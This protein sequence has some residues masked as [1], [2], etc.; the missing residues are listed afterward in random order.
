VQV[1]ETSGATVAAV[2]SRVAITL[3]YNDHEPAHFDAP[4]AGDEMRDRISDTTV[5][6]G[7]LPAAKRRVV[8]TWAARHREA[9]ALAW[10][11]CRDGGHPGRIGE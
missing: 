5:A 3:C 10:V 9:L 8:L 6:E 1:N 7:S 4:F 2:V 11:R